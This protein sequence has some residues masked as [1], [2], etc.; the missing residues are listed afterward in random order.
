[1]ISSAISFPI[2]FVP[3]RLL[4]RTPAR[5]RAFSRNTLQNVSPEDE[6]PLIG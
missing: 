5:P 1:M 2:G 6:G 4:Q 3:L